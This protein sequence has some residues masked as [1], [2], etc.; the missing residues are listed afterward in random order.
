MIL[1]LFKIE[2]LLSM[3]LQVIMILLKNCI[4]NNIK[5]KI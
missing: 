4:C 5:L 1:F 2:Y 3:K